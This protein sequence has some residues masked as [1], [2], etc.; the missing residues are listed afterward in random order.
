MLT[1]EQVD[2]LFLEDA[3]APNPFAAAKLLELFMIRPE[4]ALRV[5][6][7][8]GTFTKGG[9]IMGRKTN[10]SGRFAGDKGTTDLAGSEQ[11]EKQP[12]HGSPYNPSH[13]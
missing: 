13:D 3:D 10:D 12:G 2:E 7:N 5:R 4:E 11:T 1:P 9:S 8:I 6:V